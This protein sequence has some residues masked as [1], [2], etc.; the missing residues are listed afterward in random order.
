MRF[1]PGVVLLLGLSLPAVSP[2]QEEPKP[3]DPEPPA[4]EEAPPPEG[5]PPA[6]E[7]KPAKEEPRA[8][9]AAPGE[10]APAAQ[11]SGDFGPIGDLFGFPVRGRLAFK[12][13]GR[14]ADIEDDDDEG[15]DDDNDLYAYLSLD[16]GD[17]KKHTVTASFFLRG[18]LDLDEED[19][20]QAFFVFNDLTDTY[21]KSANGRVYHAYLDFNRL[22]PVERIRAGRQS[23]IDTP[24]VLYFDGAAVQTEAWK[25]VLSLQA[26][27]YG[28]IPV[29]TYESSNHGDSLVGGWVQAKPW[30]GGRLRA[31]YTQIKDEYNDVKEED[32]LWGASA[33]QTLWDVLTL[34]GKYTMLDH[35]ARDYIIRGSFYEPDWDLRVD[36][37]WFQLL[38]RQRIETFETD[39]F[40]L[41][42]GEYVPYTQV[43]FLA[44]KGF[45]KHVSVEAGTDIR[46][47][48]DI[49]DEGPY[50]REFSRYW[51]TP[52]LQDWPVKGL[53]V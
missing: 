44:A 36:A 50:N 26:G 2:A 24:V 39:Q 14:W 30:K 9:E 8:K 31:D 49:D 51:L 18:S 45:G 25:Q 7:D 27:I 23:M 52:M 46:R 4:T 19:D 20:D 13:R 43:R 37:S 11:E 40:V 32:H 34:S 38:R 1:A 22:G 42:A 6:G 21:D 16:L 47:L 17:A 5:T 35:R 12:Y 41:V 3:V 33:W 48:W 28:G 15:D 10:E 29:H 53:S